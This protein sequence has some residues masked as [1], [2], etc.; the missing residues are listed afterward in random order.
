MEP[1]SK[2]IIYEINPAN[3]SPKSQLC[4]FVL[5][6]FEISLLESATEIMCMHGKAA[7]PVVGKTEKESDFCPNF[8][9]SPSENHYSRLSVC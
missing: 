6:L 4:Y 5:A 3:Y 9:E 8:S 2:G 1:S 7:E